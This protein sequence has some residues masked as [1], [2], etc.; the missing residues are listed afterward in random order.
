ML[1]IGWTEMLVLGV[2]ALIVIG[3]KDLPMVMQK[4]GR[5][6][7]SI[8]RMGNEFQREI[9]RTTG[10]DEVRNLR[11]SITQPLK[12]TSDEIRRE[13]NAMTPDGPK[14]SGKLKPADPEAES[15]VDEIRAAAGMKPR[16]T[17]A[18]TASS[19]AAVEPSADPAAP[20]AT[21]PKTTKAVKA[22]KAPAT[23]KPASPGKAAPARKTPVRATATKSA[24]ENSESAEKPKRAR[25]APAKAKAAPT[26]PVTSADL[27]PIAPAEPKPAA[28]NSASGTEPVATPEPIRPAST[29]GELR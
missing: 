11:N 1:G 12:Q 8:R 27:A 4:V 5:F 28:D 25:R 24:P 2:V 14:P 19:A 17:D 21:A 13:F 26:A 6:M 18:G 23:A 29:D 20:K 22:A 16:S 9:N 7:G 15:V 3:P 10:L